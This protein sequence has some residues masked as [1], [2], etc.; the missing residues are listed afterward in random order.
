[1]TVSIYLEQQGDTVPGTDVQHTF[2]TNSD[3]SGL[4]FSQYIEVDDVPVSLEV[5]GQG[6]GWFYSGISISVDRLGDSE[7]TES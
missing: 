3:T 2:H 4:S 1:M 6:T 5:I 7:K